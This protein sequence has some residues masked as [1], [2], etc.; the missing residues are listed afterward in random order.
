MLA[1]FISFDATDFPIRSLCLSACTFLFFL[2]VAYAFQ[3]GESLCTI[4]DLQYN[5]SEVDIQVDVENSNGVE[6]TYVGSQSQIVPF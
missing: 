3:H 5:T 6:K 1:Q 2:D 4:L